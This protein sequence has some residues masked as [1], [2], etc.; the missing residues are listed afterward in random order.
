MRSH[1]NFVKLKYPL[2]SRSGPEINDIAFFEHQ[3]SR[4]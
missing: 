3:L 1:M 4:L 2:P